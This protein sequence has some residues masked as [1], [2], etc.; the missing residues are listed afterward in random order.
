MVKRHFGKN[1]RRVHQDHDAPSCRR[2]YLAIAAAY[3]PQSAESGYGSEAFE[4]AGFR[5][6][7]VAGHADVFGHQRVVADEVDG[8]ADGFSCVRK[9]VEPAV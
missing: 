8:L 3:S 6:H 7:D 2:L 9:A 5:V 4:E 1:D